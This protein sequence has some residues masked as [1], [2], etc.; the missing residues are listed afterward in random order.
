MKH[1]QILCK[2]GSVLLMSMP[3]TPDVGRVKGCVSARAKLKIAMAV[4]VLKGMKKSKRPL[5]V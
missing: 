5:V 2:N 4:N 1:V 3:V